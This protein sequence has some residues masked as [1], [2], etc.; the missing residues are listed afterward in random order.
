MSTTEPV[1]SESTVV[2]SAAISP[3]GV[4][5]TRGTID[6]TTDYGAYLHVRAGFKGT[7]AWNYPLVVKP[8]PV[9]GGAS[10]INI[11]P[12]SNATRNLSLTAATA[13]S[14]IGADAAIAATS[15][16]VASGT[17]FTAGDVIMIQ[18]AGGGFTRLEWALVAKVATN[19]LH[20]DSPLQ[21]AHTLVQADVVT[22]AAQV[23][24]AIWLPG[25]S[26]WEVIFDGA[27]ATTGSDIV[28]QAVVNKYTHDV[29]V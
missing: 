19:V 24:P 11:H 4:P 27:K 5:P 3:G 29:T 21:F 8:R 7:T 10:G 20:L 12:A 16:T 2:A 9:L 25:G 22:N 14:T 6:L 17:G 23:F 15:I 18:D 28:V 26:K 13:S 1:F